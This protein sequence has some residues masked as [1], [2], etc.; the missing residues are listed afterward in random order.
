MNIRIFNKPSGMGLSE[1]FNS[2]Y[3]Y[4][5]I[6]APFYLTEWISYTDK[7][8]DTEEKRLIGG[9]LKKYTFKDACR[10]WWANLTEEN[11]KIIMETPNFDPKI[12]LNITGI[13]VR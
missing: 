13:D 12:F 9:Y 2:K 11:K 1:F 7:E 8:M 10:N 3:Y 6:S 5:I 4:A